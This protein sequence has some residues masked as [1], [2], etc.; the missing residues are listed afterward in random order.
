MARTRLPPRIAVR[1][2]DPVPDESG[3]PL[4]G[5]LARHGDKAALVGYLR[6][7]SGKKAGKRWVFL[8]RWPGDGKRCEIGLGSSATVPLA[9][10]RK[11]AGEARAFVAEGKDPLGARQAAERM[12]ALEELADQH[13]EAMSP[14]WRN[15][16]HRAQ[17][18]M[19][20]REQLVD[21]MSRNSD[22]RTCAAAELRHGE[23]AD[24]RK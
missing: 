23:I 9:T 22:R 8:Y 12:P 19:T 15:P 3:S 11:E 18:E 6:I 10:A 7:S 4:A 1:N 2:L 14:S 13:I 21:R 20:L 16:K 5:P 24:V 17:W